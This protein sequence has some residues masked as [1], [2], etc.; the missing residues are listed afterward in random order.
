VANAETLREHE[1]GGRLTSQTARRS[2][3][4]ASRGTMGDSCA[5]FA[6]VPNQAGQHA[7][8][9]TAT[10]A[11]SPASLDW[12][13]SLVLQGGGFGQQRVLQL[14]IIELYRTSVYR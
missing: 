10:A 3:A 5:P 11:A 13:G 9:L 12:R 8:S 4:S 14:Q 1:L 7:H 2:A 6:S